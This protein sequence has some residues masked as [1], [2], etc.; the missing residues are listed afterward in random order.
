MTWAPRWEASVSPGAGSAQRVQVLD[1]LPLPSE[2]E[3]REEEPQR[4]VWNSGA[5]TGAHRMDLGGELGRPAEL[6][7]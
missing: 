5:G 6:R 1:Q 2:G 3:G 4:A 7:G